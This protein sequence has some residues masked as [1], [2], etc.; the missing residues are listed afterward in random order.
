[1][2][3]HKSFDCHCFLPRINYLKL[4]PHILRQ[5]AL[6]L[7][8]VGLTSKETCVALG[9]GRPI[10]PLVKKEAGSTHFKTRNLNT[11]ILSSH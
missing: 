10:I 7:N 5:K 8:G 2:L 9:L 11:N 1:M 6:S 3:H 4:S